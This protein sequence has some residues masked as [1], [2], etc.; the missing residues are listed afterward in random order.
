[1]FVTKT[2]FSSFAAESTFSYFQKSIECQI[3]GQLYEF[4]QIRSIVLLGSYREVEDQHTLVLIV[5]ETPQ[6]SFNCL[7][8]EAEIAVGISMCHGRNILVI[9]WRRLSYGSSDR[10]DSE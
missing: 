2:R 7:P 10:K 1:M 6:N 8:Q 5:I 9:R 4:R 3:I